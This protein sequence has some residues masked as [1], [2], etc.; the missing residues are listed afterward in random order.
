MNVALGD[1]IMRSEISS[2]NSRVDDIIK[3]NAKTESEIKWLLAI[4]FIFGIGFCVWAM[5]SDNNWLKAFTTIVQV[6]IYWPIN[7]LLRL[8]RLNLAL[9][10]VPALVV[11]S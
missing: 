10:A 1:K 7:N 6:A 4:L 8:R 5:Y 9:G 2:I 3:K 11:C